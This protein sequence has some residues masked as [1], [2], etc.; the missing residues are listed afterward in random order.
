MYRL[1]NIPL[2]NYGISPGRVNGS[3]IAVAGMLDMPARI[4]KTHHDWT[5]QQGVQPYVLASEIRYG[6]RILIF[7]GLLKSTDKADALNKVRTFYSAL[8]S[9]KDLVLFETPYG[10]YQVYIKNSIEPRY[11]GDG[12]STI[13]FE[14]QEPVIPNNGV[15]PSGEIADRPHID[16]VALDTLGM[17]LTASEGHLKRPQIKRQEFTAYETEG[18]QVTPPEALEFELG[19]IAYARSYSQLQ[20]N[21]KNLQRLLSAPGMRKVNFDGNLWEV[22]NIKGF[23]VSDI[24]LAQDYAVCRV[25]LP[26]MTGLSIEPLEEVQL[27]ANDFNNLV[28]N[29]NELIQVNNG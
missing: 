2:S 27:V 18:F 11:V 1:N 24:K 14:L 21:I 6:G 4:G 12:W 28:S 17:F 13:Q 29:L 22:F 10:S 15:L 19:I 16:G 26:L 25:K 5:G 7:N 9:W 20:E 23:S 8:G 3:N